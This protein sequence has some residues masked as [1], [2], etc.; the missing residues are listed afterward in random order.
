M[1]S[2]A[3][4]ASSTE[5]PAVAWHARTADQALEAW[6]TDA[7][8]GLEFDESRRRLEQYGPNTI[9][10]ARRRGPFVR[11]IAQ[12]NN[13]LILVLL[14]AGTVTGVLQHHLDSAV[15]FGVVVINAIIGY[16]QEG[17]AENALDAVRAMLASHA[18]V[19][20][21]GSRHRVESGELVP[22]DIVLLEAGDRVAVDL[23]LLREHGLR[24]DESALTGESMPVEKDIGPAPVDASIG[25]RTCMAYSGTLVV[26]GQAR[27]VVIATGAGTEVGQIGAMV[28]ET[29]SLA[30][31]LTTRIDQFARQ[32][33]GFIL[34]V[35]ALAFAF[36]WGVGGHSVL[37]AFLVVV[38][39]GVAAIPEGLP[40]I[41]TIVLAIGTRAMAGERAIVRRLPAVETLGSVTV[42]CS[43][44]TGTLTRNEM[45][46]VRVLLP[47]SEL[48]C[49][50]V[51]YAPDGGLADAHGAVDPSECPVLLRLATAGLLC[52]DAVLHHGD[53]DSWS[54]VGDPTE[55]ALVTLAMKAGLERHEV[56]ADFPRVDHV[57]F[58]S[59]N[60]F[61]A[62]L[63]HDHR[64]H[65]FMVLKGAPE[66]VL[67]MCGLAGNDEW[68]DRIVRAAAEGER[69][70]A[71]ATAE[72]GPE[73]DS[74]DLEH[75]PR[76][77]L[78]G[79]V[80]LLDPPRP[81]AVAAVAECQAAGITVKM[82]T[83]DHGAT[84]EAIGRELG[85][86]SEGVLTGDAI[87]AMDDE[88]L[89]AAVDEND[90]IGRA[91]PEHKMRLMAALQA[92]GHY[93]AMTGDGVNDAPA[94]KAADIGVA[95]GHRGTD[96]AR[97]ASDLVLTDDNFA[98]IASAVKQGRVVFD[99][100]KKS[101]LFILPTNGGE[102]G[103]I[104]VALLLARTMPVTVGQIL[105]VNMVT[106][107]TLAL[108][109]AFE[110]PEPGVM[111]QSPRA[112][113]EPLITR[114][115]GI[116]IAYVSFVMAL[117]T[118][119]AFEWELSRGGSI[120]VARTTAVNVLVF[121]EILYLFN[122]RHFTASALNRRAFTGN[123]VALVVTGVLIA[124]QVA[125]TY[126]PP[127]QK[128][129]ASEAL[130]W[131]SWAVIIGL[132]IAK[133]LAVE[134][135]KALWRRRGVRRM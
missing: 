17:K 92:R 62:T 3:A 89:R 124:L 75:L 1:P 54:V 42:I 73:T 123:R 133:F 18:T 112:P 5:M 30:T 55:G 20:R 69:V 13:P 12:F 125:F 22:G 132:A 135:E 99:N 96:A 44:K 63:H 101:L 14:V 78:I 57:P 94:L 59:E 88:S 84:A 34:I 51:G 120:E 76:F 95:M 102:A 90:V 130:G 27:G 15:I 82:I 50:G 106:A 66:R 104:L 6:Q 114:P 91:S 122:V 72:V 118:L 127:L 116:R 35:G 107:V 74:L 80:G 29:T 4:P 119:A 43:D 100:I 36:A 60:R 103:L 56:A 115:L 37:E 31:P 131:A 49:S 48:T 121:A 25:D 28:S 19:V 126:A 33:T 7:T 39:L 2:T 61:M 65:S 23:R 53:D 79:M 9:P 113:T 129:F 32:I 47:E 16:V 110:P 46:V 109:L 67:A 10:E 108:A 52:N 71:L 41:I 40:A 11:A 8:A 117:I 64:G 21:E 83:G 45:T 86:Q 128:V 98:T 26:H 58:E 97:E 68:H 93:V 70:L 85:L 87:E 111:R 77:D 38:G 134:A 105:W 81:E 24:V